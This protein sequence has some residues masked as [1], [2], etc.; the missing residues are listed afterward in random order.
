MSPGAG[1]GGA[2]TLF[3]GLGVPPVGG[4]VATAAAVLF[5][6]RGPRTD[7]ASRDA[8]LGLVFLLGAAG[9]LGLATRITADLADIKTLLFGTAV[10]V[11]PEDFRT[12]LWTA[13]ALLSLHAWWMPGFS[14]ASFDPDGARVRGLPVALLEATLFL[15]LAVAISVS[16]RIL[17]ALPTFAFSVL[18][19]LAAVAV[20]PNVGTALVLAGVLGAATGLGG[21]VLAYLYALPV[22]A[23]QALLG[24]GLVGAFRALGVIARRFARAPG[25]P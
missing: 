7:P 19:G 24:L 23:G 8:A 10:A 17:G 5:V 13:G 9:T 15:T 25:T 14:A 4:R 2:A 3:G 18:P 20:A 6:L 22:P 12:L 16:T 11:V 21:Y 1:V